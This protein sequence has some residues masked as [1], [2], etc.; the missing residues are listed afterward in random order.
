MPG[1]V[2]VADFVCD[3]QEDFKNPTISSFADK[4]P[5]LKKTVNVLEE[6]NKRDFH[7]YHQEESFSK[8]DEDEKIAQFFRLYTHIYESHT[9]LL[10][11]RAY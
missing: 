10:S 4:I 2:G 3:T 1:F 8:F 7:H 11:I 6:V 9:H 5:Q